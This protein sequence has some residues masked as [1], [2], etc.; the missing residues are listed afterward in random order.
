MALQDKYVNADVVDGKEP[1]PAFANVAQTWGSVAIAEIA[2]AD[3]ANSVYRLLK[4]L[5]AELVLVSLPLD[6]DAFGAGGTVDIGLAESKV[7]GEVYDVNCFASALSVAAAT[8][9]AN[10]MVAVDPAD[11]QKT[12]WEL[13]GH[14]LLTKKDSYDLILTITAKGATGLGTIAARPRFLQS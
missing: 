11:G 13:A 3:D 14:T 10:G 1:C 4:A 7:G 6:F 12:L 5:P 8:K 9:V 2:G